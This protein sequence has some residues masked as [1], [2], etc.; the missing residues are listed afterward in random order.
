MKIRRC[1][2]PVLISPGQVPELTSVTWDEAGVTFGAAS[3]LSDIE[4]EL[5][6]AQTRQPGGAAGFL[7]GD[8]V[9][10]ATSQIRSPDQ[11]SGQRSVVWSQ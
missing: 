4:T 5:Q 8:R 10:P 7:W 2:Y 6:A 1:G 9:F 11:L 3:T